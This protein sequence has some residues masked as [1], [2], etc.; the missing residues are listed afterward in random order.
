MKPL[1]MIAALGGLVLS[2]EPAMAQMREK[3]MA[4]AN[5]DGKV[6]VAEYQKSRRE[7]LMK[8]DRNNDGKVTKQEWD[9][10]A[11]DLRADLRMDGVE[12]AEKIGQG[13]WFQMIDA[14]KDM[15]I[16][17]AEIDTMTHARFNKLDGNHDGVVDSREGARLQREAQQARRNAPKG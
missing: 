11:R 2:T 10:G 13:T 12:G 16:T 9:R 8:Y 1:M 6:N 14:N 17:P 15:V 3:M 5:N 4:D 7:F